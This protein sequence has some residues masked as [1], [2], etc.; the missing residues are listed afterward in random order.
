MG[1]LVLQTS[2]IVTMF[3]K[4]TTLLHL[5]FVIVSVFSDKKDAPFYIKGVKVEILSNDKYSHMEYSK[6]V[7]ET[8]GV[9][10]STQPYPKRFCMSNLFESTQ[11]VYHPCCVILHRCEVLECSSPKRNKVFFV[12][13]ENVTFT[14]REKNRINTKPRYLRLTFE[15]HTL[16]EYK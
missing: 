14:I 5:L 6:S 7:A 8:R 13:K 4:I 1:I 9:C 2:E 12:Q 11:S 15:N 16:C 3:L 10:S